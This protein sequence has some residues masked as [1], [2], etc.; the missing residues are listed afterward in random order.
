ML[1]LLFFFSCKKISN[2]ITIFG[3][4]LDN[5]CNF[6]EKVKREIFDVKKKKGFIRE[7]DIFLKIF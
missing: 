3:N 4:K 5:T 7:V 6:L 1:L 2:L